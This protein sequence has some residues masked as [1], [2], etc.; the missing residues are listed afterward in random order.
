MPITIPPE[1]SLELFD[2]RDLPLIDGFVVRALDAG[3]FGTHIE[4]HD[5]SGT[6]IAGFP[7]Y[8]HVDSRLTGLRDQTCAGSAGEP[9]HDVEQGWELLI[10]TVD[11]VVYVLEGDFETPGRFDRAF[12]VPLPAFR[13]AWN[14]V[15]AST[16]Q[17]SFTDVAS[18]LR[19]IDAARSLR[20]SGGL[21]SCPPEV[22]LLRNLE[23]L[24]LHLNRLTTLPA[25]IGDLTRLKWLDLR[26][27]EIRQLPARLAGLI[28][29]ESIN[30]GDNRLTAIPNWALTLPRLRTF[31][32]PGNPIP[33][34]V[35]DAAQRRRPDIEFDHQRRGRH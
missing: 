7:W 23:H 4:F 9:F 24:D 20:L 18:A 17:S 28:G 3:Q 25:S 19:N 22:G 21:E 5:G 8:D 13:Q 27:N 35:L 34:R 1:S 31:F 30:L 14:D 11:T 12:R 33:S 16:P 10:W 26:F 32:V 15:I 2:G 29:I 6:R